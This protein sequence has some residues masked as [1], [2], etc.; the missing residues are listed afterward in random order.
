MSV[1]YFFWSHC[2]SARVGF[3]PADSN[4]VIGDS[5]VVREGAIIRCLIELTVSNVL[6]LV[7]RL[8]LNF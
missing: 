1:S 6:R 7:S 8:L 4:L 2:I 5:L 3:N